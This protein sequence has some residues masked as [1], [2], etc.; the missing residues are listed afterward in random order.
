M[1]FCCFFFACETEPERLFKHA[2]RS[3]AQ[4]LSCSRS[5]T[6]S[7]GT[8]AVT[9]CLAG[10]LDSERREK[11]SLVTQSFHCTALS[12]HSPAANFAC[13]CRCALTY[14][15]CCSGLGGVRRAD[16]SARLPLFISPK[17]VYTTRR[18]LY[19]CS[20]FAKREPS[21]VAAA[22]AST[23]TPGRGVVGTR[24]AS[25]GEKREKSFLFAG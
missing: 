6:G 12:Y 24:R 5:A 22:A 1:F 7:P 13:M 9:Q 16:H 15:A 19:L 18:T 14:S 2:V 3:R 21:A 10:D 25:G 4:V 17:P 8:E 11:E 20:P 23:G